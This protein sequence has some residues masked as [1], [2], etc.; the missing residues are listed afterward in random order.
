MKIRII[1]REEPEEPLIRLCRGMNMLTER[2]T[3][4][5]L[6][7]IMKSLMEM[8]E[9]EIGC[10]ELARQTGLNRITC[11]YHMNRLEKAGVVEKEEKKYRL[12]IDNF[13]GL[14]EGMRKRMERDFEEFEKMAREIDENFSFEGER[15]EIEEGRRGGRK[16]ER[17][18][19][20][21]KAKDK[22]KEKWVRIGVE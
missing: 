8:E 16:E 4:A 10:S 6:V 13:E 1:K 18:E 14:V 15:K 9:R 2:D 11:I 12:V 22:E 3:D 19:R 21:G 17:E 20:K 5:T 7:E